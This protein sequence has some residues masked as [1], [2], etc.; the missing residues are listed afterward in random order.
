MLYK[1]SQWMCVKVE[2]L[3]ICMCIKQEKPCQQT[4]HLTIWWYIHIYMT[5]HVY[6]KSAC[7]FIIPPYACCFIWSFVITYIDYWYKL[8]I[9]FY[10]ITIVHNF[11]ILLSTRSCQYET[12][13]PWINSSI[14]HENASRLYKS[15]R[16]DDIDATYVTYNHKNL[17]IL[18]V[19]NSRKWLGSN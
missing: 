13:I 19:Y 9:Y 14:L 3:I 6:N 11:C 1:N 5:S 7:T 15:I 10:S 8:L 16:I 17:R 18:G 12:Q 2:V 4:S